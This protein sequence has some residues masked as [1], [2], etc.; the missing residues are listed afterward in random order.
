MLWVSQTLLPFLLNQITFSNLLLFL[1]EWD[2]INRHIRS[3]VFTPHEAVPDN[4]IDAIRTAH[5]PASG[6]V[7]PDPQLWP[8][9]YGY[10]SIGVGTDCPESH[11]KH[12]RIVFNTAFCGSVAGNR[13]F[14]DC[15]EQF[16]KHKTCNEYIKSEPEALL[17]AY[18]K[19]R[20]V[21]V[22]E[23]AWESRWLD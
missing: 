16:Q 23:R 1:I 4:L 15:P 8:L 20:G 3:W 10:F 17:E 21:Y 22:Y 18:W 7:A 13:Y 6:R 5:F 14:M 9:P 2:P 12:M 11:F 19:I